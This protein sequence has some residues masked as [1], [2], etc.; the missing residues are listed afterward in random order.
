MWVG[1]GLACL[2]SAQASPPA[3]EPVYIGLDEAYS[4]KTNTAAKA[5]ERG[6]LAAMD[7][8]NARGGV[9][10]GRPLKLITTDNQGVSARGRDNFIATAFD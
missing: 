5:I 7:E 1:L 8:I 6:V 2:T 3:G 9:L 10:G 4:I